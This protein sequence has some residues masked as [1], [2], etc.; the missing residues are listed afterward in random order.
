MKGT[1]AARNNRIGIR[2]LGRSVLYFC[3]V[4]VVGGADRKCRFRSSSGCPLADSESGADSDVSVA[5]L[6]VVGVC[7]KVRRFKGLPGDDDVR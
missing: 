2:C 7:G 3:R 4:V 5:L 1:P 6:L